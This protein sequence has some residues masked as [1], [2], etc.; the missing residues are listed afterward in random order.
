MSSNL[1]SPKATGRVL[2]VDDEAPLLAALEE[3]LTQQGFE[4]TA[5][6][7]GAQALDALHQRG[8]DLVLTDLMMPDIDGIVLLRA[9]LLLDPDLVGI[10]M[11]GQATVHTAVEAMK[12]GAFDYLLK[13]FKIGTVLPVLARAMDVR[14]LRLENIQL[15]QVV[16]VHELS[17]AL[18]TTLDVQTIVDRLAE[19]AQQQ[20]GADAVAVW[21]PT[22][23]GGFWRAAGVRGSGD[24]TRVEAPAPPDVARRLEAARESA[25]AVHV[26]SDQEGES[27]A[28]P[29]LASGAVVG[30]LTVEAPA[31]R[32]PF[33]EGEVKALSLLAGTAAPALDNARLLGEV[34]AAEERYRSL[35]ENAVTGF[36]QTTA[37][38][39]FLAA[40]SAL[41]KLL[42][43]DSPAD[44]I[45]S[46]NDI[47]LQLYVDPTQRG[48]FVQR[49]QAHGVVDGFEILVR[50][51]DGSTRW[52]SESSRAMRDPSGAVIAYE[53]TLVDV[54]ERRERERE[55]AAVARLS[56]ALR[57]AETRDEMLPIITG[58]SM[59]AVEADGAALALREAA[60]GDMVVVAA[61]G[62]WVGARGQRIP[63]GQGLAA[64]IVAHKAPL[65][66]DDARR[67]ARL[68]PPDFHEG[69]SAVA[70]MPL[71]AEEETIGALWVGRVT[72]FGEPDVRLLAAL[73][74]IAANAVRRAAL[75]DAT[76]HHAEQLAAVNVLGR[77]LSESL[78]E[79]E[80]YRRLTKA[81]LQLLPDSVTIF[82]SQYD[83]PRQ[84]ITCAYGFHEG[85]VVD[86]V[87]LPAVPLE[88]P[89]KGLQSDCIRTKE[90]IIAN[91]L[92]ERLRRVSRVVKVGTAGPDTQSAL[93]IPMLA[94][95]KVI[96][97]VQVQSMTVGRYAPHDAELL[98]LVA[99]TAAVSIENA[100]LFSETRER[101]ERLQTL[102]AVDL[103]IRSS[104]D[105]PR[106]LTEVLDQVTRQLAVDA[107]DVLL[108]H[109]QEEVLTFAAGHGFR[110]SALQYTRLKLGEGMAGQAAR[111]RRIVHIAD[112]TAQPTELSRSLDLPSE[113][114]VSYIGVPL[115]V[116]GQLL[117]V[118]EI[119]HR[120]PL[121]PDQ[122]WLDFLEAV[123]AQAA[124]A[125]EN[126][127]LF[128]GL[129][130]SH[131]ELLQAYDST[132]EGW[133]GALD[134]RDRET[135]GHT[136]RVTGL[137]V[138]LAR[139]VGLPEE[140]LV[141]VR[142]GALL[143]DIGKMGI[144][145]S[146]LQKPGPLTD[147]EWVIMRR[148]PQYAYELLSPISFLRLALDI[149]YCHH[150]KWD[151]T[152]Y[153]RALKGERIPLAARVFAVLDVWDALCY[154]RPYRA[155]WPEAKALEYIRAESGKHFDPH[156]AD[157]FLKMIGSSTP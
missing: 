112:L 131:R 157:A 155:A 93:Y 150:E 145:D 26:T 7:S 115:I 60:S 11:T 9:A 129:Q 48:V 59:A 51:K 143:H 117:G 23:D 139:A 122:E 153:P 28:I 123:A 101:L 73:G 38:G 4:V 118:L 3:I 110:S 1:A 134:L 83:E 57:A 149:P 31:A 147:D 79:D 12:V 116:V 108:M 113:G 43:F 66:L 45:A 148:H 37:D 88:P 92:A 56:G 63:P 61:G 71:I 102:H 21:L 135:V 24:Q 20:V 53:G 68:A 90:P 141:H 152:G 85:Q 127:T 69:L 64:G 107:A 75:F 136:Q 33:S 124:M 10:V 156:I 32:R 146:I 6:A 67:D 52:V 2:L 18:A 5:V 44:L 16:T 132:L 97:V 114:F 29:M 42:G 36:F 49:L 140:D 41:A 13:P 137:T 96:G 154:D 151:G 119:L 103:A 55:L 128:D 106:M 87:S 15:R 8:F 46:V 58:E 17:R 77:A 142:R 105:L 47:G 76:R 82:V 74:D 78:D 25:A 70:G 22:G 99:N 109:P 14:R 121:S 72:P 81:T 80:I 126:A 130:Q 89:G 144:P 138:E 91:D 98:T 86:P 30:V 19:A 100:R 34:R 111:D 65:S 62:R 133:I 54:T 94:K 35:F 95:G 40:N 104:R 39:R 84:L 50:R 120:S 27:L 125:I